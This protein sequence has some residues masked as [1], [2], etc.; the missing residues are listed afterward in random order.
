MR[1]L[2]RRFGANSAGYSASTSSILGLRQTIESLEGRVLLSGYSF[3]N[4]ASF[5]S[6]GN[7]PQAGVVQDSSG[8]LYG[9]TYDGGAYDL[10]SLWEVPK[11]TGQISLLNLFIGTNGANPD[12]LVIDPT[13]GTLYGTTADGGANGSGSATIFKYSGGSFSTLYSFTSSTDGSVPAALVLSG[14][15]LY[16]TTST[17]GA[18]GDGTIFQFDPAHNAF[19]TLW[20]FSGSDGANPSAGLIRGSNGI[21]YGTTSA[22]GTN[23]DGIVFQFNPSAPGIVKLHTFNGADGMDPNSLVMDSSGNFFGSTNAGGTN[24]YGNIFEIANGSFSSLYTFTGNNDGVNPEAVTLDSATGNLYGTAFAG[25]DS[26]DGTVFK[27]AGGTHSFSLLASF[28]G[29]NNGQ[30]PQGGLLL[31]SGILYGTA[32]SG[33]TLDEGTAFKF[34]TSSDALSPVV[35]FGAH[36]RGR[37]VRR[38]GARRQRALLRR[39][40]RGR[41]RRC[42]RGLGI[43][44]RHQ[45]HQPRG[46]LQRR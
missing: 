46:I 9:L 20:S 39:R 16:G 28:D 18:H 24:T 37:L 8:N 40:R 7:H 29:S 23:G 2:P 19:T 10:G 22:G 5:V 25:G 27:L 41:Y 36:N 44:F 14:G 31:A 38:Y 34:D 45:R 32:S 3:Q 4:L 1:K 33:G 42:G 15:K 35:F 13:S 11:A 17:G 12:T 43:R 26:W 21:L 30:N 6:T